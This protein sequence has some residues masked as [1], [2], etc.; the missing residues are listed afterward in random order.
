[1]R[2]CPRPRRRG[3]SLIELMV[4][5]AIAGILAAIA[6][7]AYT[8]HMQRGRRADGI[9]AL[10]AVMQ[11]Q[12]RYRGNRAKYASTLSE[13]GLVIAKITPLYDVTL[14]GLGASNS[15]DIGYIATATPITGK[16]QALDV[17]CKTLVVKLEGATPEYSATG[18]PTNS[19]TNRDTSAECWP[20]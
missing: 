8:S 10:T 15:F 14:A 12:E 4:A 3:F 9:A 5:L 7:P 2:I 16:K 19:G 17:T 11:A 20:R 18:D 13:L 1:M 6:Y